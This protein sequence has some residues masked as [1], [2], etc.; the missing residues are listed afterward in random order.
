MCVTLITFL[1]YSCSNIYDKGVCCRVYHKVTVNDCEEAIPVLCQSTGYHYMIPVELASLHSPG[2]GYES[3]P[4]N[5]N[6]DQPST[7]HFESPV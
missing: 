2:V 6:P 5:F 7:G 4:H 3:D 1:C